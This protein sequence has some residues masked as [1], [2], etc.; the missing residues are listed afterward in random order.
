MPNHSH[1]PLLIVAFCLVAPS[2]LAADAKGCTSAVETKA[3]RL[4]QAKIRSHALYRWTKEQCL[5][6][7]TEACDG[8]E[9]EIAVRENHTAACGGDPATVPVADRFRVHTRSKKIEWY[10]AVDGEY[11]N[12]SKVRSIGHR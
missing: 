3:V 11:V 9:A 10:S 2:A 7:V 12:F 6:F 8:R 5:L 4:L 1:S